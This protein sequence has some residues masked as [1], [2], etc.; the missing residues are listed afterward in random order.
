MHKPLDS[1]FN[2]ICNQP[3][4]ERRWRCMVTFLD[5][6]SELLYAE[7]ELALAFKVT[8]TLYNIVGGVGGGEGRLVSSN[9]DSRCWPLGNLLIRN[10][11]DITV[12][13]LAYS[14]RTCSQSLRVR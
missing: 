7:L 12:L 4:T 3:T 11:P 2:G 5:A 9:I 1:I 8:Y 6:R 14:Y 10:A 13:V